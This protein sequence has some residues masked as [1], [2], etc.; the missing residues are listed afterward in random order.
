MLAEVYGCYTLILLKQKIINM[1]Q[2]SKV[3]KLQEDY[4]G[5]RYLN[6][7]GQSRHYKIVSSNCLPLKTRTYHLFLSIRDLKSKSVSGWRYKRIK[8]GSLGLREH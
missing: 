5:L 7:I 6:I 1:H 8:G 3:K 2:I 4:T